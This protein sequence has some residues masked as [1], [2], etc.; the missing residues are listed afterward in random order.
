MPVC[1]IKHVIVVINNLAND[2]VLLVK[3]IDHPRLAPPQLCCALSLS[4][5]IH[6]SATLL[7]LGIANKMSLQLERLWLQDLGQYWPTAGNLAEKVLNLISSF[8][9]FDTEQVLLP[10]DTRQRKIL[11]QALEF[12]LSTP[13]S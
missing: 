6:A 10:Y 4:S 11:D 5:Y 9:I 3:S 8:A 7:G 1:L 12:G 13:S 2:L